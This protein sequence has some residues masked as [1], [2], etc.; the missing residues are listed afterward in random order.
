M[1]DTYL[2]RVDESIERGPYQNGASILW[3]KD[4]SVASHDYAKE[5]R[6]MK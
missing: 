5:T 6:K 4:Q 2:D 3:I 1:D